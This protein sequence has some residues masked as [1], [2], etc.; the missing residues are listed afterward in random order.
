[1]DTPEP[2]VP[3]AVTGYTIDLGATSQ[4]FRAGH[5]IRVDIAS[6][7]F[8]CFDR[9]P[10]TGRPAGEVTEDEFGT[11]TQT[12]FTGPAHPSAIRLPV[13]PPTKGDQQC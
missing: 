13:I 2:V 10:G 5:R 9:N 11:A 12:V 1:M 8:P 7:N 3:G 6:S 4:V